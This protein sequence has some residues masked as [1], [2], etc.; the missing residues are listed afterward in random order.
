L[1]IRA[2]LLHLEFLAQRLIRAK[3]FFGASGVLEPFPL[4]LLRPIALELLD[5]EHALSIGIGALVEAD[6]REDVGL[7][8]VAITLPSPVMSGAS[9]MS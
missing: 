2:S 1:G 8:E 5:E 9:E 6:V 7:V 3:N 4:A